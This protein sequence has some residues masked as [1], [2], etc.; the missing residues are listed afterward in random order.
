MSRYI[1]IN[2]YC[3]LKPSVDKVL[4]QYNWHSVHTLSSGF[5]VLRI[6]VTYHKQSRFI[7]DAI[8]LTDH[9][10]GELTCHQVMFIS[11]YLHMM[12]FRWC[13]RNYMVM[14][15]YY[16]LFYYHSRTSL[17][18]LSWSLSEEGQLTWNPVVRTTERTTSKPQD[19][20]AASNVFLVTSG[21]LY[22][23]N[24]LF[25][26]CDSIQIVFCTY[27]LLLAINLRNV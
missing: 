11:V 2:N 19:F 23:K 7:I 17:K 8:F 20:C 24:F 1:N 13:W 26:F 16:L 6:I 4:N 15:P 27:I 14:D 21:C 9:I 12:N 3:S 10:G 18:W 5:P 22:W 25:V